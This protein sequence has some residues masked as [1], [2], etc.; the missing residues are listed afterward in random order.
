MQKTPRGFWPFG[1]FTLERLEKEKPKHVV[2][3][4]TVFRL[5]LSDFS[6]RQKLTVSGWSPEKPETSRFESV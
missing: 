5:S 4:G 1:V 6:D 3:V 2:L